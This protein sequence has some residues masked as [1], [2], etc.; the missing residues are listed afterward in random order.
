MKDSNSKFDSSFVAASA[1]KKV[2]ETNQ[3]NFLRRTSRYPSNIVPNFEPSTPSSPHEIP[4]EVFLSTSRNVN[5]NPLNDNHNPSSASA[6]KMSLSYSTPLLPSFIPSSPPSIMGT[7]EE[8][9][10]SPEPKFKKGITKEDN[11][12]EA[13]ARSLPPT[14]PTLSPRLAPRLKNLG[15]RSRSNSAQNQNT[16]QA[17][18]TEYVELG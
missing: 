16:K 18:A 6:A 9:G 11:S 2:P 5:N 13:R 7:I 12:P 1:N 10:E 4:Q 3:T 14:S 17:D 15:A 8:D